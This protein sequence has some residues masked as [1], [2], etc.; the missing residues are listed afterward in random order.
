[1]YKKT[2]IFQTNIISWRSFDVFFAQNT[3]LDT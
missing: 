1:M 3:E 2:I